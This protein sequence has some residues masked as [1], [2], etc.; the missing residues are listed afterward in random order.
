MVGGALERG[1]G[2]REEQWSDAASDNLVIC[3]Q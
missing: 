3:I 2:R 1:D